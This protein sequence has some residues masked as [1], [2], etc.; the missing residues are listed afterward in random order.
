MLAIW[1]KNN[2]DYNG[3]DTNQP[4]CV[5]KALLHMQGGRGEKSYFSSQFP[6]LTTVTHNAF[7]SS[8]EVLL[9]HK[10]S[11]EEGYSRRDC[12]EI[13]IALAKIHSQNL[14]FQPQSDITSVSELQ[15]LFP[16]QVN[17]TIVT[18]VPVCFQMIS[19]GINLS[20]F[21]VPYLPPWFSF[22]L[23]FLC[24]TPVTPFMH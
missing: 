14:Q 1:N 8:L 15:G 22:K 9:I 21:S 23:F 5:W 11:L 20:V 10:S 19:L 7:P 18:I 4:L 24:P 13:C 16:R 12:W 3:L 6:F 17:S 2:D